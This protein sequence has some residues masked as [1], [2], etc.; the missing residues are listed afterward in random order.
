MF[1]GSTIGSFVPLLWG[2]DVLSMSSIVL[3]AVGGVLGV[4]GGYVVGKYME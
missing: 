1:V 2:A 4:W 3:T